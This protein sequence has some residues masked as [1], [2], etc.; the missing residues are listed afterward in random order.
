[1]PCSTNNKNYCYAF[2]GDF[3]SESQECPEYHDLLVSS[4]GS[5][6][7][8]ALLVLQFTRMLLS[9]TLD[10]NKR[11]LAALFVEYNICM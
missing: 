5:P 9:V 2:S 1:M 4:N 10:P 11:S 3:F 6:K 8:D 7:T